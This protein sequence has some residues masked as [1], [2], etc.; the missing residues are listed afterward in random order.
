MKQH[1][2][3]ADVAEITPGLSIPGAIQH[4]PNGRYLIIQPKHLD[5]LGSP[6]VCAEPAMPR[7]DLADRAERYGVKPGDVLFMSRGERNRAAAIASST[8]VA[9]PTVAFFVL[10]PHAA[11][12][13]SDYLV[14]YLNQG[15]AQ[16]A[17]A[18]ARTGAGT[19]MVQRPQF[20]A[21]S[22]PLPPMAAQ[23]RIVKLYDL[24]RE[25]Q[26]LLRR[27]DAA[28]ASRNRATAANILKS[29]K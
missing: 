6:V 14:W 3:L 2:R 5:E 8:G 22:I 23:H 1:P 18:Q 26:S 4:E 19:P 11:M 20:E 10:R 13:V 25:E 24:Q 16:A 9:V 29:L 28:V 27:M 15:E 17:I 7:M 21:L 12:V